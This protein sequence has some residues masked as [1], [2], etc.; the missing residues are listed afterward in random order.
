MAKGVKVDNQIIA[1]VIASYA[2]TNSYNKTAKETGVCANTVKKIILKQKSENSENFA[3]VCELKKEEFQDKANRIIN[4][5]MILLE[6]KYDTALNNQNEI[7]EM[8]NIVFNSN[9]KKDKL[10]HKEKLEIVKR[11]ARLELN[12]LSEITTSVG[13]LFDKMRLAKGEPTANNEFNVKIEVV[14]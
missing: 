6:R 8:I 10:S 14:K 5:A 13:T 7:E 2:L 12:S 3:K 1:N 11:L 4:K 9:D